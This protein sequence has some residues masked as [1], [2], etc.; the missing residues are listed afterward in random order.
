MLTWPEGNGH[1]AGRM[2]AR[3]RDRIA[4]DRLTVFS[5]ARDG[6]GVAIDSLT[7]ERRCDPHPSP[8]P[9]SSPPRTSSPPACSAQGKAEG[10][11]YAPWLVANVTVD[12]P[13]AGRGAAL[14]WDNVSWTSRSLGYVVATHQSLDST[15]GPTVLTWYMPLSDL[16][17]H[18]ARRELLT[19]PLD[20]WQR[21]VRDD[22]LATNPDLAGAIRRIDVWRWGHAMIRPVPGY[23]F[24]GAREAAAAPQ[25]PLFF[26]HS[27]LSGLSLFE[28]AH[29]C[30]TRAAE[31]AMAMLGVAYRSTLV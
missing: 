26:A 14:A 2:A 19:R 15:P 5:V 24:G 31:D 27:D 10:F 29:Y 13:P 8:T 12:R 6:E 1:L 25:P 21:I 3:V 4:P 20:H 30:G 7:S 18:A 28:E 23:F 9:R 22:L 16:A 11:G 17:P